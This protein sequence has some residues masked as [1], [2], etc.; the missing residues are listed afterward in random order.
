MKKRIQLLLDEDVGRDFREKLAKRGIK[1]G[2]ISGEISR[3]I[4][5]NL[6]KISD[7][8]PLYIQKG[9]KPINDKTLFQIE[10]FYEK[11]NT[12][13]KDIGRGLIILKDKKSGAYY[14]ECHIG[15]SE[16][17]K[18]HDLNSQVNPD[19]EEQDE[20]FKMNRDIQKNHPAFKR[21]IADAKGGRQFS[22]LVI[23]F[24]LGYRKEQPLKVLGGQHRILAI[25]EA[26]E[27]NNVDLIHGIRVYF[28]LEILNR[29]EIAEVANTNI[30]VSLDLRDKMHEQGLLPPGK[31]ME[32][33]VKIGILEEGQDFAEKRLKEQNRPT[34][35]MM[36]AFIVNF[37][38]GKEYKAKIETSDIEP[39]IPTSGGMDEKYKKIFDRLKGN[40][41]GEKDLTEAGIQFVNLNNKQIKNAH[42][43]YKY[44]VLN[45]AVISAWSFI[46]GYLRKDEKRL[47]KLYKLPNFAGNEDPLNSEAMDKAKH[48]IDPEGYR[49]GVRQGKK[50]RGRLTQLFYRFATS[51]KIVKLNLKAYEEAIRHYHLN[52][53]SKALE[54]KESVF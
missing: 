9:A 33:C 51:D 3:L 6:S 12:F 8:L 31:L 21:M 49:M 24:N 16:L 29:I 47:N 34:V 26:L 50:E 27:K 7:K 43:V 20:F 4:K 11:I 46:V 28:D 35:R 2:D 13:E 22:D 5:E 30:N 10:M 53:E 39:D 14:T 36:R 37:Y 23:E 41:I 32:W 45:L 42:P 15:P 17:I 25:K 1:K 38:E 52:K 40:F 54:E 19:P 48:D 18:N 44:R